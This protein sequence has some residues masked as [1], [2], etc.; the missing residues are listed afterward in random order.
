MK[1]P[2]KAD[3]TE[4]AFPAGGFSPMPFQAGQTVN[5]RFQVLRVVAQGGMGIV[6]EAWDRKVEER[7]ALK[8]AK[9]GLNRHLPPEV[10]HAREITHPNVCKIF[11]IH[12]TECEGQSI[13]FISMEFL[14]GET[15]SARLGRSPL[16]KREAQRI[17]IQV[18]AGLAEAHRKHVVHGDLK[19]SNVILT[20]NPDGTQ[21]AVITDFG[22]ARM[23]SSVLEEQELKTIA[24]TPAYMAPEL[25]EGGTPSVLSDIY[26][27]GVVLSEL[28]PED[29]SSVNAA[30][31]AT[32]P[33]NAGTSGVKPTHGRWRTRI[34]ARCVHPDPQC[35]FQ[36]A[37]EVGRALTPVNKKRL[38]LQLVAAV[39]LA[40]ASGL[41]A[42]FAGHTPR[43]D[44]R[45]AVLPFSVAPELA[46]AS[47]TLEKDTVRQ[48]ARVRGD[49][50]RDFSIA[51]PARV[52]ANT[53][54]HQ[55]ESEAE[56]IGLQA[57]A[58]HV[59][60]GSLLKA[61]KHLRV[62]A[63]LT[64]TRTRAVLG[65]WQAEFGSA[66]LPLLPGALTGFVTATLHLP[67]LPDAAVTAPIAMDNY[68]RGT[69]ALRTTRSLDG[70]VKLMTKAVRAKED[71][72]LM[73]AGL[74]EAQWRK[75]DNT[76]SPLWLQLCQESVQRAELRGRDVA[77]V[78]RMAG[79]LQH[80]A[81]S[82]QRAIAEFERAIE[83]EPQN[84][85][86]YQRI[87]QVYES[88]GQLS[89]AEAAFDKAVALDPQFFQPYLAL[90]LFHYN[91]GE[92]AK[93]SE[94]FQ[95]AA[96][97]GPD[98]ANTHYSLGS[99]Y[100]DLG[101]Y[102]D[103]ERELQRATSIVDNS[104]SRDALGLAMFYQGKQG[105]AIPEFVRAAALAPAKVLPWWHLGLCY[106]MTN[107]LHAA[108]EANR[109]GLQAAELRLAQHPRDGY[110]RSQLAYLCAALGERQRA[111]SEIVQA[112]QLAPDD[113]DVQSFAVFTY[114]AL[115]MREQ[116]LDVIARLPKQVLADLRRPDLPGLQEDPRFQKLLSTI[117][118]S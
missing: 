84:S 71:S 112:L 44:V 25:W 77:P 99:T 68:R 23:K 115:Q 16:L 24:G 56:R 92:F 78:H 111:E 26:A 98:E 10:R 66:D 62:Q 79:L 97:L 43:E 59:L 60:Y 61:G 89:K 65:D 50:K 1:S 90:G 29:A 36:S 118:G 55:T 18:C 67:A 41:T 76:G 58:T 52:P 103:A 12:T 20:T 42:Y 72:A 14:T 107:R 113:T 7:V 38:I 80:E 45:M 28:N 85:D 94:L 63:F 34:V 93:A 95:K 75:Y 106:R 108:A 81:G 31:M 64:D 100:I 15:L 74:A 91:R 48:I 96:L 37:E 70:A 101:K 22:L 30:E 46:G 83:L 32:L 11:E 3:D 53:T 104:K 116:A 6:Y 102:E 49:S 57:G 87:G 17:A 54:T 82:N 39:V 110:L 33:W 2:P 114:E 5:G 88:T 4:Y 117:H 47:T 35:R 69:Q 109:R 27:L 51:P 40:V 73:H 105:E 13:D 86:V 21:R 9:R 19:T 8:C